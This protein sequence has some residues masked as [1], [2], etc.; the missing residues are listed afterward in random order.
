[1]SGSVSGCSACHK[2]SQL[3]VPPKPVPLPIVTVLEDGVYGGG[4]TVRHGHRGGADRD[5]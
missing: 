3:N 1:M 2:Q 4:S 5:K